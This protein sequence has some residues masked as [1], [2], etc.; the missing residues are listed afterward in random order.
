MQIDSS[1]TTTQDDLLIECNVQ[2]APNTWDE[3][4]LISP[5]GSSGIE[6]VG[7]VNG[8]TQKDNNT[9]QVTVVSAESNVSIGLLFP[10]TTKHCFARRNY[11]CLLYDR[12]NV[13]VETMTYVSIPGIYDNYLIIHWY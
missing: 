8:T 5:D 7:Y 12:N 2:S 10:N 11:T 3:I 6:A 13:I 4:K 9:Y 1:Q